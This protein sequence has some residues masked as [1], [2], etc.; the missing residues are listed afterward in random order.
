M[1]KRHIPDICELLPAFVSNYSEL[2]TNISK[3]EFTN[4]IFKWASYLTQKEIVIYIN[5]S[6]ITELYNT[7]LH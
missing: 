5:V 4:K 1:Y 3:F 6:F 7:R 2:L